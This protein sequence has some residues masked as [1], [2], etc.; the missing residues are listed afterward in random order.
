M[1]LKMKNDSMNDGWKPQYGTKMIIWICK[2]KHLIARSG[3]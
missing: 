2:V 1:P 3:F